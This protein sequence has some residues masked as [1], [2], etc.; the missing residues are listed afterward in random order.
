[1]RALIALLFVSSALAAAENSR[2]GAHDAG[3]NTPQAAPKDPSGQ[4]SPKGDKQRPDPGRWQ[5]TITSSPAD[6]TKIIT[7]TLD[8]DHPI[9]AGFGQTT[10]QLRL[11]YRQGR[12]SAYILFD[13]F[14]GS[15]EIDAT[16]TFG[17]EPAETQ[18][19]SISTDG[20]AAFV[21]GDALAFIGRLKRCDTLTVEVTPKNGK[22]VT[23]AFTVTHVDVVIA[24]LISVGVKAGG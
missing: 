17:R 7:A 16:V 24:A 14:L 6:G 9:P 12:T 23:A 1:M 3:A 2:R 8:A 10:P 22:A 19:W 15:D 11:R 13:T 20:R 21:P 4:V 18:K 5:L